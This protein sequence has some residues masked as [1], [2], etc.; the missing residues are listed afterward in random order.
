[1]VL[2]PSIAQAWDD[3]YYLE[4][5]CE[6]ECLAAATGRPII[7]VDAAVAQKVAGQMRAGEAEASR[8]HLDAMRRMMDVEEPEY[9]G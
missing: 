2:A 3:L 6:T 1:M 8:M 7:P 9:R 5:A 4:R